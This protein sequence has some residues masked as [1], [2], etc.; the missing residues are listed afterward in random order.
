MASRNDTERQR[1]PT[2]NLRVERVGNSY[3][4]EVPAH[5]LDKQSS[6]IDHLIGLA[7]DCLD[8][9]HLEVRVYDGHLS[10]NASVGR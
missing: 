9:T 8:A 7:F 6:A 1:A 2:A 10:D 5:A 4:A 3:Y